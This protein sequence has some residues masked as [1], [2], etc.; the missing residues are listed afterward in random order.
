MIK[1]KH[2]GHI[3]PQHIGNAR[4][5]CYHPSK[6]SNEHCHHNVMSRIVLIKTIYIFTFPYIIGIVKNHSECYDL[7]TL[8]Y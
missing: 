1:N 3:P 8:M 5:A 2:E 7:K 6:L 4:P